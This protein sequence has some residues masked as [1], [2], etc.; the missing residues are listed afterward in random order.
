MTVFLKYSPAFGGIFLLYETT[1][2]G[3]QPAKQ[4]NL[5]SIFTA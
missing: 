5:A 1:A 3:Q 2:T 4:N